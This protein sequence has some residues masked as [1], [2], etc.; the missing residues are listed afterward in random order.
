[1]KVISVRHVKVLGPLVAVLAVPKQ[2]ELLAKKSMHSGS[3][4]AGT[5][6]VAHF[7]AI[8]SVS[9]Q[10]EVAI[11]PASFAGEMDS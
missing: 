4:A 11:L 9:E 3:V 2:L 8:T 7:T 1:M 10:A 5:H 6:V